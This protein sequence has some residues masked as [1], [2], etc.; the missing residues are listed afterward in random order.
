MSEVVFNFNEF[1][2]ISSACWT[3]MVVLQV[4]S[5]QGLRKQCIGIIFFPEKKLLIENT[6][7]FFPRTF[8]D[9]SIVKRGKIRWKCNKTHLCAGL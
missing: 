4:V 5:F 6:Y 7:F 1:S 8:Q 3:Q 2:Q 9:T